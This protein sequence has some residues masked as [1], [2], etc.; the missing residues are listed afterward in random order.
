VTFDPPM[1]AWSAGPVDAMSWAWDGSGAFS[2][3][4]TMPLA[5]QT[6]VQQ[7]T[8]SYSATAEAHLIPQVNGGIIWIQGE[9]L[10]E[11]ST[12]LCLDDDCR[13]LPWTGQSERRWFWAVNTATGAVGAT[14]DDVR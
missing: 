6:F 12:Q 13:D 4:M 14:P 1:P 9:W 11:G 10:E 3:Q 7:Q 8:G 2:G 5:D